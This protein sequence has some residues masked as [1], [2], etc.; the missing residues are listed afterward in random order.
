MEDFAVN[1][2]DLCT[3]LK[4]A[5]AN[6]ATIQLAMAEQCNENMFSDALFFASEYLEML[7]SR[8]EKI[9]SE[10]LARRRAENGCKD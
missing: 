6:I 8:L 10:E 3:K 5:A 2:A 9:S 4:C 7:T 1:V